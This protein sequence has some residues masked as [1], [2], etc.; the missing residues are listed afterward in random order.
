M[1]TKQVLRSTSVLKTMV[2]LPFNHLIWLLAHQDFTEYSR[3]HKPKTTFL[4]QEIPSTAV[5]F[6]DLGCLENTVLD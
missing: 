5:I 2:Y 1:A 3:P 6:T 4:V